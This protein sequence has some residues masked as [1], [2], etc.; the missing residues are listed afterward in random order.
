MDH[1]ISEN[2][3]YREDELLPLSG[4][5]HM[6]YCERQAALIHLEQ[7]WSES[8]R[9]AEGRILHERSHEPSV[10]VRGD[11]R[12][13][14]G[15]RIHSFSLGI[16]GMADVVEFHRVPIEHNDSREALRLPSED[17]RW[18][19]YPIEY[20]R[21][22]RRHE[23]GYKVQV[24]AQAMC[25]EEMLNARVRG[26][27][28]YFG[29][30]SRRLEV[31]FDDVLRNE[32]KTAARRFHDLFD[33]RRVP[34]ASFGKKCDNCSLAEG[35]M[36]KIAGMSRSVIAYLSSAIDSKAED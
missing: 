29:E 25:L 11:I 5:E 36:P 24:C 17:G 8:S 12:I 27:A 3:D 10:E 33:S 21:G 30:S 23:Q 34:K 15:L 1:M 28:I 20:K 22:A 31:A 19:A 6:L 13:A 4:L 14:R 2:A 32:T 9:T 18:R 16:V 26:G 7:Y 35:C